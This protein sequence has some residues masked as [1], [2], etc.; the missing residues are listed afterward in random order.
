MKKKLTPRNL[1]SGSSKEY[2]TGLDK[3]LVSESHETNWDQ[4]HKEYVSSLEPETPIGSVLVWDPKNSEAILPTK[5]FCL[6][7]QNQTAETLLKSIKATAKQALKNEDAPEH[8]HGLAKSIMRSLH[9]WGDD[10]K[11]ASGKAGPVWAAF[12]LGQT[13]ERL[14]LWENEQPAQSGK[15]SR[16]A[17]QRKGRAAP[18]KS[19]RYFFEKHVAGWRK[20]THAQ[21]LI[22][23]KNKFT[24]REKDNLSRQIRNL[25]K[26][27]Q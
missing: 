19:L 9:Y 23:A 3:L 22:I 25:K 8:I 17:A 21:L 20:K 26:G 14:L 18:V 12:I 11:N 7:S 5:Q 4:K 10:L 6:S 1:S 27:G 15:R 2:E 16:A 13:Y 24:E